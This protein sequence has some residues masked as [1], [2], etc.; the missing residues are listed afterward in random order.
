MLSREQQQLLEHKTSCNLQSLRCLMWQHIRTIPAPPW[1]RVLVHKRLFGSCHSM[2]RANCH[3]R[4]SARCRG[5]NEGRIFEHRHHGSHMLTDV[6]PPWNCPIIH[7]WIA[8]RLHH[9]QFWDWSAAIYASPWQAHSVIRANMAAAGV[10]SDACEL[11]ICCQSEFSEEMW[12]RQTLN[13]TKVHVLM[14]SQ[15]LI[16]DVFVSGGLA[17]TNVSTNLSQ[18]LSVGSTIEFIINV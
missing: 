8:Q 3:S 7:G 4:S 17:G 13:S 18:R 2:R 11:S 9:I 12:Q 16:T 5:A 15:S 6:L 1:L 14:A 10:C